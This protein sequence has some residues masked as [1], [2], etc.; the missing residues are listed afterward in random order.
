[1]TDKQ[2]T[3]S[4]FLHGSERLLYYLAALA[5]LVTIGYF[6]VSS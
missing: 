3:A 4:R 5:L 2:Q 6:L 1:M